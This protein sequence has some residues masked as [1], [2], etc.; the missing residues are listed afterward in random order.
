MAGARPEERVDRPVVRQ[1]W[2]QVAFLHWRVDPDLVRARL[3]AGFDVDLV[4]GAAWVGITP[5]RVECF[6]ALGSP[7][8]QLRS[9]FPETNLRTYVRDRRGRDGLWFLSLDVANLPSL[10]G[11]RF[12][13]APYSWSSMSV[14]GDEVVRYRARRR[15][16]PA[17][18]HDLTIRPGPAL[19]DDD[20]ASTAALLTGRWRAFLLA[21]FGRL[22][23]VPVAH[24]PWPLRT[25]VVEHLDETL[26]AAAGLAR[27]DEAPL[28]HFADGVDAALGA[29]RAVPLRT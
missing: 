18:H 19:G 1:S 26:F 10:V 9:S 2:R 23:V 5:F 29:A 12:M 17:A 8:L 4:D 24:Q 6:R 20:P 3:P 21:P 13:G 14:E 22:L 11:G 25:A 27:P 7:P 28:V 15:V 16:G